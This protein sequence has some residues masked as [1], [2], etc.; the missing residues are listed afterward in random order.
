MLLLL[1]HWHLALELLL[2]LEHVLGLLHLLLLQQMLVNE[3]PRQLFG[4]VDHHV[5]VVFD[6]C[7]REDL[8]ILLEVLERLAGL[9]DDIG[10][11]QAQ[12]LQNE[13]VL[14]DQLLYPGIILADLHNLQLVIGVAEHVVFGLHLK[15][16]QDTLHDALIGLDVLLGQLLYKAVGF[17]RL[18]VEHL[19]LLWAE[20]RDGTAL[21]RRLLL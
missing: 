6:G 7:W 3:L 13:E 2:L 10:V 11:H 18:G 1:L 17:L 4:P 5:A 12:Q 16:V 9:S 15:P 20:L 21:L 14:V 8:D 19:H